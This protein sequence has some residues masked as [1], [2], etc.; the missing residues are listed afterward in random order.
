[1]NKTR[2]R[3]ND[4]IA[5]RKDEGARSDGSQSQRYR[6]SSGLASRV[7]VGLGTLFVVLGT[8]GIFLPLLPTTPFLLLATACYARGSKRLYGWLLSNRWFGNYIRNYREKKAIPFK[9]KILSI[10]FLWVTIGYSTLFAVDIPLVRVILILI[11]I[12]VTIH[13]IRIRTLKQ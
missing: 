10:S 11:A 2:T 12:T 7:W 9:I 4:K 3:W 5:V 8:I 1:M 13:I 6:T